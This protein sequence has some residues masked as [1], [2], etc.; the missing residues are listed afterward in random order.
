M[1]AEWVR[2]AIGDCL[3]RVV[4]NRGK[5]PP[6]SEEETEFALIEINSI[7]GGSKN[8][9]YS[10]VRKYVTPETYE[11]WFRSGHPTIGDV[12]FSTVGSIAEVAIFNGG[13]GCVAQNLVGL[14]PKRDV[15]AA[16]GSVDTNLS[17]LDCPGYLEH[18]RPMI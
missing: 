10:V 13:G 17:E 4:D 8:P 3:E 5:T 12:L 9:D 6:L 18:F 16:P 15:W 14:R 2:L 1:S 11:S 7:V